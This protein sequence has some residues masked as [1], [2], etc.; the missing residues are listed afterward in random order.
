MQHL[1]YIIY[2]KNEKLTENRFISIVLLNVI[3]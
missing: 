3:Y 2:I 1:L